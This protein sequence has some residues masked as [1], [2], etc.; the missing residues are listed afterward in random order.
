VPQSG[1]RDWFYCTV[2]YVT[3]VKIERFIEYLKM[4]KIGLE[5][6]IYAW[7]I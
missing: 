6:K 4:E 2:Y 1:S 5:A 3:L 7:V